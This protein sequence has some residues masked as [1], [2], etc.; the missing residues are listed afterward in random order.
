M[1]NTNTNAA[2]FM[3]YDAIKDCGYGLE[4]RIA[5]CYVNTKLLKATTKQDAIIEAQRL[6]ERHDADA[7]NIIEDAQAA[8][9]DWYKM[10]E[11]YL[12]APS[13]VNCLYEED[14]EG[15]AVKVEPWF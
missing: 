11:S 2:K 13:Y 12:N 4:D 10:H 8:G 7:R 1:T 5:D 6:Q 14:E 15:D 3:I 9:E